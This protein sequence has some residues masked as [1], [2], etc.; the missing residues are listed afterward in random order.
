MPWYY[1][2]P[3]D[4]THS[5]PQATVDSRLHPITDSMH[6]YHDTGSSEL[7]FTICAMI[8]SFHNRQHAESCSRQFALETWYLYYSHAQKF[9]K[10]VIIQYLL[11]RQH[12]AC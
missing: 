11:N 5:M 8:Q 7:F 2:I 6:L 3:H 9:T 4:I 12:A 10:N 1:S